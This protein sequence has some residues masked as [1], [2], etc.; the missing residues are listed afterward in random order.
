MTPVEV[1]VLSGV[2]VLLCC[3]LVQIFLLNDRVERLEKERDS[4][5]QDTERS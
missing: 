2:V 1:G 4:K 5:T 3:A